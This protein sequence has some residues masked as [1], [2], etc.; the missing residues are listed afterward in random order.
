MTSLAVFLLDR[1]M[2]EFLGKAL[3]GFLVTVVTLLPL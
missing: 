2:L 1:L 3:L